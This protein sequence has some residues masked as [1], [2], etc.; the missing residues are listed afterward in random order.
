MDF[1]FYCDKHW[2]IIYI[3]H[4][5][6]F[7]FT[8]QRFIDRSDYDQDGHIDFEDFVRYVT[9]HEKKLKLSFDSLDAKNDGK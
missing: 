1:N 3:D 6:K 5:L 9:E 8:L 7:V 4:S 2:C